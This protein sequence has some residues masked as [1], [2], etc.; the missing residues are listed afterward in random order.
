MRTG[1]PIWAGL[2]S[3]RRGQRPEL[4]SGQRSRV[5]GDGH[6]LVEVHAGG[7]VGASNGSTAG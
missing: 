2:R 5:S 1:Q 4:S 7:P 3:S 6:V